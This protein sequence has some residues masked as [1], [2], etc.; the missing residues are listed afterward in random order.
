[1]EMSQADKAERKARVEEKVREAIEELAT[2][3]LAAA[4][5]VLRV[6][7]IEVCEEGVDTAMLQME[8]GFSQEK[9]TIMLNAEFCD[10]PS[11]DLQ[12]ILLH[13]LLHHVMR[14]LEDRQLGGNHLLCNVVQDAF[15]N[16]T[17]Y[18]TNPELSEF[19]A[20]YY[21]ADQMPTLLLR[22]DSAPEEEEDQDLYEH[23][24]Q[25]NLTEQE[26][27]D[28]LAGKVTDS[29]LRAVQLLGGHGEQGEEESP[30][31]E[32]GDATRLMEEIAEQLSRRGRGA[33]RETETLKQL[34]QIEERRER[35][36]VEAAFRKALTSSLGGMAEGEGR[37]QGEIR[38]VLPP[39]SLHRADIYWMLS[40]V[41]PLLW[42][43][44]HQDAS[45]GCAVYLDVSGSMQG[46]IEL[47]YSSCLALE[48]MLGADIYLFSNQVKEIDL[49][50]LKAGLVETS[51]GTDFN[52]VAEHLAEQRD[53]DKA[54]IF[55][56]GYASMGE[57]Q[58]ELLAG[59]GKQLIGVLTPGGNQ[60]SMEFCRQVLVMPDQD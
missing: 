16:R 46:A 31:I 54:V 32:I 39:G 41:Q 2:Q 36:E 30:A 11:R 40:G 45:Q 17:I 8:R 27:Y 1:M 53:I 13:E 29:Q 52:C 20:E 35:S 23:L 12:A 4:A 50:Q 49:D 26:L 19:M 55:T 14:H 22:P 7:R 38:R 18:L 43:D 44:H 9:F 21:E 37:E 6:G 10:R 28:Q 48:R 33:G 5:S 15:I 56:D 59:R 25:G 42:R 58:K 51:W 3:D 60:Q 34:K 24:Y 47:V 57:P